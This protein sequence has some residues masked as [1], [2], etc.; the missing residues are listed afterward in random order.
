MLAWD[1][2]FCQ[3]AWANERLD[4]ARFSHGDLDGWKSKAFSGLTRYALTNENGR[5]ALHARSNAAASG[6]YREMS[7]ELGKTPILNWTWQIGNILAGADERTR[8]GDDYPARVYVIFSGGR[9]LRPRAIIR[10]SS[11]RPA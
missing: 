5:T 3:L 11:K 2:H 7:I 4:V 8:A 6:L 10:M 1:S 9:V